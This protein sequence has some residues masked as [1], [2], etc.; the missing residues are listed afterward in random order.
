ML[1]KVITSFAFVA[2]LGT[3]IGAATPAGAKTISD[4]GAGKVVFAPGNPGGS[5]SKASSLTGLPEPEA[6]KAG[7][8]F[9]E[10][11]SS[12]QLASM[13]AVFAKHEA[14]LQSIGQSLKDPLAGGASLKSPST[15][16]QGAKPEGIS[17]ELT[18]SL[19]ASVQQLKN[20]NSLIE[21]DLAATLSA[22]QMDLFRA[23]LKVANVEATEEASGGT[24][25]INKDNCNAG[26]AYA[27]YAA[28]Y[29]YYA[30]YYSYYNYANRGTGNSYNGYYYAYYAYYYAR[31]ALQYLAGSAYSIATFSGTDFTGGGST[32]VTYA[33]YTYYYG[34]YATQYNAAD[35][36]ASGT[37]LGYT[38]YY[39]SYYTYQ[40]AYNGYYYGYY[41]C[42]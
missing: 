18:D 7:V 3:A 14:A 39:Y 6:V 8:A 33:Y 27:T 9:R 4:G 28:A 21:Q 29:S 5:V 31:P 30:Y 16:A 32:G 38:A 15:A 10:S 25:Q 26:A 20:V 12:D 35:Y 40:Y 13:N 11:L 17:Q 42:Q 24:N 2:I 22:S 19:N 34:Y 37:S 41:G 23:G 36:S 1:R